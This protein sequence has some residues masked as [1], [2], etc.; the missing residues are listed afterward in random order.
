MPIKRLCESDLFRFRTPL[1]LGI[2]RHRL[3]GGRKPMGM[4]LCESDLLQLHMPIWIGLFRRLLRVLKIIDRRRRLGGQ[5]LT[6][7]GG[8]TRVMALSVGTLTLIFTMLTRRMVAV[9][10]AATVATVTLMATTTSPNQS[11]SF[12]SECCDALFSSLLL[13]HVIFFGS[14][15]FLL[16]STLFTGYVFETE[17][18]S[19]LA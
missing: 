6:E 2:D 13:S 3:R 17:G 18:K 14:M 15:I 10:M 8:A 9:V 12:P 19:K 7:H 11:P 4:G 1:L 16:Y 5:S